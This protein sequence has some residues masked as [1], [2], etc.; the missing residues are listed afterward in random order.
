MATGGVRTQS[1]A[2][3]F[4]GGIPELGGF[5][6]QACGLDGW[7]ACRQAEALEDRARRVGR[8]DRREQPRA[9][10]AAGALE[11]VDREDPAEQVGP[12]QAPGPQRRRGGPGRR[13]GR[14]LSFCCSSLDVTP[15]LV[16]TNGS[17][18]AR[19]SFSSA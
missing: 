8:L 13:L 6:L 18:D 14:L 3:V 15:I 11:H 12:D 5:L 10:A 4:E 17:Q 1:E 9:R 19:T 7:G 2:L 16:D